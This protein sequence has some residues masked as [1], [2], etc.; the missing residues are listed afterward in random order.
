MMTKAEPWQSALL[1]ES[2][3]LHSMYSSFPYYKIGFDAESWLDIPRND[4]V[5]IRDWYMCD[6]DETHTTIWDEYDSEWTINKTIRT[7]NLET[8]PVVH[9]DYTTMTFC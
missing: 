1:R 6:C 9:F 2:M 4:R 7:Y 8:R 3:P 5:L